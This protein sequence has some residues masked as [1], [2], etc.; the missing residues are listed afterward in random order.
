[1][2][3]KLHLHFTIEIQLQS[4]QEVGMTSEYCVNHSNPEQSFDRP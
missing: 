2:K 4:I 1:M 3:S